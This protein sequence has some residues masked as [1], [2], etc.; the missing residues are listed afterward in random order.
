MK[1]QIESKQGTKLQNTGNKNIEIM[2]V[3]MPA[4]GTRRG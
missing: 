1:E 3:N 4:K 2:E